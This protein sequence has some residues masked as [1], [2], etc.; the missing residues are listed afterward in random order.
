[1]IFKLLSAIERLENDISKVTRQDSLK[2]IKNN[3]NK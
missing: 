3:Q 2:D 1:M